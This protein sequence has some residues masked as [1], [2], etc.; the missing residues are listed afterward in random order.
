M[1]MTSEKLS[2]LTDPLLAGH[3]LDAL[4]D[5][6]M[7]TDAEHRILDVNPAFT[8]ITGYGRGEVLGRAPSLLAS[9]FHDADFYQAMRETL[10]RTGRWRGEIR[11]RRKTGEDYAAVL[12]IQ[13]VEGGTGGTKRHIGI[14]SE[15][16]PSHGTP[17]QTDRPDN[18]DTLTQL[19]NRALL[20]ERLQQ[21][22]SEAERDSQLLAVIHMDMDG[23]KA[24]NEHYGRA[25]GDKL[26]VVIAQRLC[27]VV[28]SGDTV[29][30]L[31]GD[32]FAL[33]VNNL[34]N[35][36]ELE[37]LAQRILGVAS[38]PCE[39]EGRQHRLS[40]SLGITVYPFDAADPETLLRHADQA[41]YQCKQAGR[42]R[43]QLFD[44]EQ[45]LAAHSRRRT[46]DR[47]REAL[48]KQEFEL[49][50]Q[51]KVNLRSGKVVGAEALLRWRHPER[52]LVPPGEFL[53]LIEH[54]ELIVD[55]GEWVIRTALGQITAWN[56]AG[57]EL[58]VSVNIAARQLQ[59]P[60][61]IDCLHDCLADFPDVPDGSLE[62][63]ILES[64]ALENTTHVREVINTCQRLGVGF[65]LDDF[66]TGFASLSYLRDIPA[67]VLKIDQSFV[68]D[69]LEDTDDLT[70]VDGIIGLANAFR[71]I[72]V[73]EGVE[74]AEQG[75]LLMRLGCDIAQGYGIARPMPADAIPAWVAGYR[76]DPQWSLWA[77][78]HWEMVDFPLLVAQYDHI[79]WVKQIVLYVEGATLQLAEHELIDHHQ[80]R[81]GHWYYGHGRLRYGDIQAF[82]DLEPVHAEVH[83]L[84]P[85]IVRLRADGDL[86]QARA[87]VRALLALKDRIL[88]GLVALQ[89]SVAAR[90]GS[91]LTPIGRP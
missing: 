33:V 43:Y 5:A 56:A 50:Y 81:F 14:L 44:A 47:L 60:D 83:R 40:A 12:D 42:N 27:Q 85:E 21:A 35:M 15:T 68:R 80:C 79:K 49:H 25:T 41:M 1:T 66:G 29:A 30:R 58:P 51:P 19:P 20:A 46:L 22:R 39:L 73:A 82:A 38:A 3:V 76:P 7:L 9:A 48:D 87:G 89:K 11:D 37:N 45:D 72:V 84:G 64:A 34:P 77:D 16:G 70:L 23:F 78:T 61:F 67:D 18:T 63:E 24:L 4:R 8:A 91:V 55:L 17:T 13:V 90:S 65:A 69:V 32:E 6:V 54:D 28:R 52:G 74:T 59:R 31:G 88:D 71:R 26:L 86:E 36:D 2:D 10:E 62:L 57:L 75:V 53:P